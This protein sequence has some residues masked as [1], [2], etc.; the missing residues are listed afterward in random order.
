MCGQLALLPLQHNTSGIYKNASAR[1]WGASLWHDEQSASTTDGQWHLFANEI[2]GGCSLY[3]WDPNSQV[4]HLTSPALDVEFT[5]QSVV[6]PPFSSNPTVRRA[7]DGTYVMMYIGADPRS[8]PGLP[9]PPHCNTSWPKKPVPAADKIYMATTQN[10]SG[11]WRTSDQPVLSGSQYSGAPKSAWDY[12]RTNPAP[13]IL[14]NGTV[15]LYFRGTPGDK[16][17][18]RM[19]LAV[20]PNYSA[21]FVALP[22][23]LIEDFNEVRP[24]SRFEF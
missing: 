3:D 16:Y 15:L 13:L 8:L 1:S 11:P 20:A 23:P 17:G 5:R 9:Q 6:L 10:L 24:H 7:A 22:G 19:G 4:V 2:K 21:P 18:E 12:H 14:P